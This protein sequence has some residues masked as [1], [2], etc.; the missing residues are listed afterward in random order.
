MKIAIGIVTYNNPKHEIEQWTNSLTQALSYHK[1]DAV[2]Y[3]INNG[4][5]PVKIKAPIEIVRLRDQGNI[6]YTRGINKLIER[7][8][9]KDNL[10]YFLSANP[11]G[12]FH[13]HFFSELETYSKKYKNDILEAL[14][15]P[16]EHTKRYNPRTFLTEWASGCCS[17]Y[18]REVFE[19]I[20]L[21]DENFFMY[22]ED[23]DFSWRARAAGFKIRTCPTAKYG[24]NT[25]NRAP[26]EFSNLHMYLSGRY[27]A[28]KWKNKKFFQFCEKTLLTSN[29]V[30]GKKSL[31]RLPKL[32]SP[33]PKARKFSNFE[34]F[35]YFSEARW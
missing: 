2:I 8:I 17:L 1:I 34:H 15:F 24:H 23:V 5:L 16:D 29:L 7:A 35:F 25:L 31:P 26:S 30:S 21:M 12:I 13:P 3:Q 4:K 6:G 22:V 18:P 27:L 19:K 9:F 10:P 11:D 33:S 28:Y 32:K 14:Q 20:G